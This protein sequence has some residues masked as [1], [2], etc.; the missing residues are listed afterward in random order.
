[1]LRTKRAFLD[2]KLF[3]SFII[4][5]FIISSFFIVF[6]L[7]TFGQKIDTNFKLFLALYLVSYSYIKTIL[8]MA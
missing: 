1:M 6:E 3:H 2:E 7:L 4:S 5:Y 8:I